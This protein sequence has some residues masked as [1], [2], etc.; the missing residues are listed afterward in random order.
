M[1]KQLFAFVTA[2]FILAA[3]SR[4]DPNKSTN[5]PDA[6]QPAALK[7]LQAISL[8]PAVPEPSGLAYNRATGG[9][10]VVSDAL[11]DIFEIGLDGALRRTIPVAGA[12]LEG[13]AVSLTGDSLYVVEER[14]QQVVRCSSAG[15]RLMSWP[16]RVATMENSGLEGIAIDAAGHIW[17]A[18]EK[19]P[20][21]LLEFNGTQEVSRRE[22]T[23]VD[24]LSGLCCD[25]DG[26]SL[27]IISDESRKLIHISRAGA[28][29]GEWSLPFDKGEGI[30]FA[31]DKL[32]IVNDQDSRLYVF[33]KPN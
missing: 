13:V 28:L 1:K 30:A 18:N 5:G 8:L 16:A 10:M 19:D 27:W 23:W 14:L 4:E 20:R 24:D 3:C 12:D 15:E 11:P 6:S 21:L 7:P 29:L 31:G 32:Y 26:Q 22:I 9:L 25:Q 17:V 2:L 33:N